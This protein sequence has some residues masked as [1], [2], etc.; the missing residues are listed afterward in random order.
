MKLGIKIAFA[1]FIIAALS[2]LTVGVISYERAKTSLET[3]S[4]NRLTAVREVKASQI[5]DYFQQINNQLLSLSEDPSTIEAMHAFKTAYYGF[6]NDAKLKPENQTFYKE[7]IARYFKDNVIA[8]VNQGSNATVNHENLITSSVQGQALQYWYTIKN[9]NPS[10]EKH[11]LDSIPVNSRYNT[12]HLKY[13]PVLRRFLERFGYYDIFLIDEESGEIVYTVYKEMDFGTSLLDGPFSVTNLSNAYRQ[14]RSCNEKGKAFLVDFSPYLPSYNAHASF[15]ACP[16]FDGDKKIGVLAF[17]MPI[18]NINDIMTNKHEWSKVGLGNSGETYLVGED[19]TLRNQSRFL[20]ED[21]LNYFAMLAEIGT[22]PKLIERI[23][24]FNNSVGLQEVRTEGTMAALNGE[25]G[26][27]LFK[28]YR[29]VPVLSSFKPLP[30]LNMHWVIMSEIDEEEA[31]AY[32]HDLKNRIIFAFAVLLLLVLA[33]SWFVSRQIV[34]PLKILTAD[35]IEIS[36]GNLDVEINTGKR[37]DEIGILSKS[38]ETMQKSLAD[39]IHN[40]EDKVRARTAELVHQKNIVEQKQK[41]IVDSINYA[42][43]IQFALLAHTEYMDQFL[44]DYFVLFKPKDIVSGDFY[45]ATCHGNYFYLA[46]CDCTGHGV[47]GA[48]MSLLNISFLNEAINEKNIV[49][50]DLILAHVRNRLMENMTQEGQKDGMDGILLRFNLEQKFADETEVVY[51]AAH[52]RPVLVSNGTYTEHPADKMPVGNHIRIEPYQSH[53]I[54][55]RKGDMLFLYTDGF[56]DQFGGPRGKKFKYK[57]LNELLC[58]RFQDNVQEQRRLLDRDFES[59]R[60]ELEQV[61][62]VCLVGIRI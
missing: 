36:H 48:F 26:Q 35:A 3:E 56:A 20:I 21:S 25:S 50:P 46:V 11:K 44:S 57:N 10:D 30:L 15:I 23:R 49:E 38:F 12:V 4:F 40:L 41:E 47:P 2:M 28:D 54:V 55:A 45:W 17:Q 1:F 7:E 6:T 60:G 53:K 59:W 9:P 13:H 39:L 29:G 51:C 8:R 33:V 62:D 22:N 52:N 14:A 58:Q 34:K 27:K 43:R 24:N 32:V 5:T 19:F 61:D 37:K 31:F 18:D 42:R 16:I